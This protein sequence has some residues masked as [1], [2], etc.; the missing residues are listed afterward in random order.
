MVTQNWELA[1][2]SL[3]CQNS[4]HPAHPLP[5][6]IGD[7]A[8]VSRAYAAC[9]ALTARHSRTFSLATQFLPRFKRKAIRAL[10]AFCRTSDDL[11]DCPENGLNGLDEAWIAW[12][13][14]SLSL[15]PSGKDLIAVAWADA[16][17]RFR[18]PILFAE[19]LLD[20][21]ARDLCQKRYL[22][23]EELAAYAYGVASTVGLM[24]M[25]IIGFSGPE[26]I[27]YAIK[28][29]V[30]LQITNILRDVGEDWRVGRVYLPQ[31]ELAAFGLNEGDL[32]AGRVDE[33]WRA[34]MRFQIQ[35][36][37]LLYAEAHPGIRMLD[38]D[39]RFAVAAAAG[40]YSG[41]LDDIEAH[42]YDVFTRRAH[43]GPVEKLLRLPK[44]LLGSTSHA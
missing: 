25:H 32:A 31:E 30:A 42:D 2:L 22:T 13:Q 43:L 12:R 34:F 4:P 6:R 19:Q 27:P 3:A 10:Y 14:R 28:L 35:R 24:S 11:V 17:L 44:I 26:A 1:L 5:G 15:L 18:I 40:L 21:I 7:P 37:R 33:R 8:L 9:E 23:F 41:I 38:R 20:G 29:G 16:R 39:G 36:N